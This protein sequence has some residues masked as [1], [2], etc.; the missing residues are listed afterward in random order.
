[1]TMNDKKEYHILSL[2]GGKDSAA[3][4][5]YMKNELPEIHEKIEYFFCDT[6]HELPEVYDYLNKLEIFLD[7]PINRLKPYV[8]FDHIYQTR[9]ILPTAMN[10][11]C[12]VELKTKTMRKM[13]YDKFMGSKIGNV[14]LYI[15]IRGDEAHRVKTST[16]IDNLINEKFPFVDV[17]LQRQDIIDILVKSGLGLPDYMKWKS[18]SGCYFCFYQSKIEWIGLYENHP[19]LYR[20]AMG[21]EYKNCDK[22]KSGKFG[23]RS[24]F[25]LEELIEPDNI[26]NIKANYERLKQKRT[27]KKRDKVGKLV[28]IFSGDD[29][30]FDED[31]EEN[32]CVLCHL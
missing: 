1:M 12:T 18:R 32:S 9:N 26:R 21:Y 13:I 8:S 11:W 15:G 23:W 31:M 5:L 28:N 17:G 25:S 22:I 20:K 10:R 4:A 14:N 30:M 29:F 6:E 2:S 19:E 16:S 7:K 24:D 3:L 27:S